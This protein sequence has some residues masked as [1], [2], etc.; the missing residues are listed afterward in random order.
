MIVH[1]GLIN[2]YANLKTNV[3]R[4]YD[5]KLKKIKSLGIS[6]MMHGYI[7]FDEKDNLLAPFKTWRNTN[8]GDAAKELSKSLNFNIPQRWSIAHLWQSIISNNKHVHDVKKMT[9]LAGYVHYK[10]SGEHTL[11]IGEASGMFPIDCSTCDYRADMIS[12]FDDMLKSKNVQYKIKDILPKVRVAG[13]VAGYLTKEGSLFLDPTGELE[14]G[15]KMCPPEGDAGTGM[16]ATNSTSIRT[17]NISV[18]T[19]VFAMLVLENELKNN[20]EEIDIVTTPSGHAVAMVH[21]NNCSS[22]LNAWVDVFSEFAKAL[23]ADDNLQTIFSI[24]L[25]QALNADADAGG[26]LAYNFLSGE[27]I[28]K[29]DA[30]RPLI[31][32]GADSKFNLK[33]FIRVLLY[34]SFGSLRKGMDILSENESVIT[35]RLTAHGGLFKTPVVAQKILAGALNTT[36]SV[37]ENASEGGAWGIAILASYLDKVLE[38]KTSDEYIEHVF[39]KIKST[40]LAPTK[41]DVEGFN[42]FMKNFEKG[43][44]IEREAIKAI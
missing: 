30:G 11:G 44:E 31:V 15:T 10:L 23:G 38:Y 18:G 40:V 24:L 7:V 9:T 32:R 16:V 33:N 39:S 12:K 14:C 4:Q 3:L 19:S 43:L 42:I 34:S 13:E 35:N 2:C 26:L 1:D 36:I 21:C 5:I 6:G 25:N 41:E 22:D 17:G 28:V 8:T 29:L 37:Q 27:H 20:Y